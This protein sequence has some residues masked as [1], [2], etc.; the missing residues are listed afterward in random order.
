M[1][2]KCLRVPKLKQNRFHCVSGLP[3]PDEINPVRL[4]QV[5]IFVVVSKL[6]TNSDK[7]LLVNQSH[8]W[9][10]FCRGFMYVDLYDSCQVYDSPVALKGYLRCSSLES[11]SGIVDDDCS[12]TSGMDRNY[13]PTSLD[14]SCFLI[15]DAQ[16]CNIV[17]GIP[18]LTQ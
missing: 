16:L 15:A 3:I 13:E 11:V 5:D 18:L 8:I 1:L 6:C 12:V 4:E 10:L 2:Y 17:E 9:R 14:N 7:V